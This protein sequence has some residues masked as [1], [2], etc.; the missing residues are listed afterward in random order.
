MIEHDDL[1]VFY[2]K[3]HAAYDILNPLCQSF[4]RNVIDMR[5]Y[6]CNAEEKRIAKLLD[7][8]TFKIAEALDELAKYTWHTVVFECQAKC[9]ADAAYY[10]ECYSRKEYDEMLEVLCIER[11]PSEYE[12]KILWRITMRAPKGEEKDDE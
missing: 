2:G 1:A 12:S 8:G 6:E 11:L 7:D 4:K 9:A 10:A 3:I 5:V